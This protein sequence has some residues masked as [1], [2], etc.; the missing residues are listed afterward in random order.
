MRVWPG[1]AYPLGA[2]Y[3]GTGT[4]FAVFSEVATDV[5]L[6]LIDET[7]AEESVKLDEVDGFVWHGYLPNVGPGQRYGYRIHGPYDPRQGKRCNEHK[8]LLDPYA[9]AVVGELDLDAS[10]FGYQFGAPET[11]N[12]ASSAWHVPIAVVT[13]PFFDW[14]NDRPPRIPYHET[15]IYETHVRGMTMSHPKVPE[16]LRGTYA[17]LAHPAVIEHL[18]RLGVTTVELMPVHHFVSEHH[19]IER[20]LTNYWG[21]NTLAFL[22]PHGAYAS[23]GGTG[24]QVQE[25][26]GMVRALHAPCP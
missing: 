23:R 9:K 26:K 4:N 13:N 20:G 25:F 5:E 16:E 12:D 18:L 10:V 19:L 22:D 1:R 17:G 3:D 8:L 2:T 21:Y 6:C 7:G 11:R 14:D 24:E 15:V